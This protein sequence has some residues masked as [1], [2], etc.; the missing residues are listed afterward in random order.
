MGIRARPMFG[1][2]TLNVFY[3]LLS[4]GSDSPAESCRHPGEGRYASNQA[5][6]R[7]QQ[8]ASSRGDPRTKSGGSRAGTRMRSAEGS[9][10]CVLGVS[11][12]GPPERARVRG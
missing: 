11:Y 5:Q 9:V 8:L 6:A 1:F 12:V 2:A 7:G 4:H 3:V 10:Y